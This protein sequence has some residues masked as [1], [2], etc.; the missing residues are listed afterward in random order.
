MGTPPQS[1]PSGSTATCTD[2]PVRSGVKARCG[3]SCSMLPRLF[4]FASLLL[5]RSMHPTCMHVRPNR[6]GFRTVGTS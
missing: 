4:P 3:H 1:G 5:P 2:L 6:V